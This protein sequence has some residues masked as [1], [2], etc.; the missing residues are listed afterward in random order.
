MHITNNM[1]SQCQRSS[2]L[3]IIAHVN[4]ACMP[5]HQPQPRGYW[6]AAVSLSV[7]KGRRL[8]SCCRPSQTVN[9]V[10]L[11]L[12]LL[13]TP[14]YRPLFVLFSR[15]PSAFSCSPLWALYSNAQ[16]DLTTGARH[17]AFSWILRKVELDTG[18][19][20]KAS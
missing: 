3:F 10:R 18:N 13:S 2:E 14:L 12:R 9:R 5:N 15:S 4:Y 16:E 17:E 7:A 8:P 1:T 20:I 6:P 11:L 19:Q